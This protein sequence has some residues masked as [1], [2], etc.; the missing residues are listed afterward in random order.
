MNNTQLI[1][2]HHI[3]NCSASI[4]GWVHGSNSLSMNRTKSINKPT[5][6]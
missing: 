5:Q 1:L 4:S 2:Q 3:K 6:F